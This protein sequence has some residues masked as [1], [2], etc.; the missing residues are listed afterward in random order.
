M[1]SASTLGLLSILLLLGLVW[2]WSSL[3]EPF[4]S[5]TTGST[6]TGPC[7]THVVAAGEK[8][9]RD[10][11]TVS[12]FNAGTTE[13][14]AGSTMEELVARGFGAGDTGNAPSDV[15]VRRAEIWA[16]DPD[17]PAV[18]LVA[19]A[20]QRVK[21]VDKAPLGVGVSVVVGDRVGHV[22]KGL[23]SVTALTDT[24]VCSPNL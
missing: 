10:Q 18:R 8:V 6:D 3:T 1:R 5:L 19:S 9:R 20:F 16:T 17:D 7:S 22:V 15:R 11:V 4:P 24:T 23:P 14:L 21:V 12:V 13:G 2:G